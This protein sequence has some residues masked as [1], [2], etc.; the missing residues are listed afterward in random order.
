ML[1]QKSKVLMK[2]RSRFI[3]AIACLL[4]ISCI[5]LVANAQQT[6]KERAQQILD[7]TGVKGGLIIHVGCRDAALTAGLHAND[8]YLVQGLDTNPVYVETARAYIRSQGLYGPVTADR[9][10][11]DSLPYID[12]LVNLVVVD[13]PISVTTDEVMRVLAPNGVAYIKDGRSWTMTVKPRPAGLDEWTHYLYDPSN[14]AVSQDSVIAPLGRFQWLGSPKWARHH[15]RMASVTTYIAAGGRVFY[16][17]D[18]GS[19]ASVQLPSRWALFARD[20]FNGTILWKRPIASWVTQMWPFKSG[21]ALPPRRLVAVGDRVYVTL[22]LDGTALSQLDAA[23]GEIIQTYPD[24]EMTEEVIASEGVL[25]LSVKDAPPTTTWNE[26]RPIHR[27]IG[28]AK[29]RVADEYP[30]DEAS[31]RIMAI[32]AQTGTVLWQK[33]YPAAP[34]TLAVAG[35]RVYFHDGNRIICLNRQNGNQLWA[36]TAIPRWMAMPPKFGPTLVVHDDVVLFEGGDSAKALTALSASTGRVLWTSNHPAT[37]HNCPYDL[38]VAGGLAWVGAI[39]GGSHSGIFT[40]WDPKTGTV[41]SEFPP[42]VETHWFHHRCYRA[43]ATDKYLLTSR[44]GIE[45]VDHQAQQWTIHHWVRGGCLYGILPANGLI[46]TPPHDCACYFES[47]NFGFCALAPVHSDPQYPH[48]TP[49]ADRLEQGPAYPAPAAGAG[50]AEAAAD[51]DWPTYRCDPNRSGH[52]QSV[53]PADLKLSWQTQLQGRLTSPVVANGR[54]YVASVDLHTVY[55]LNEDDGQVL[56]SYMAGGRVDSPPSVYKGGVIFGCADGYVYCLRASDGALI[57]RFQ[58]APENLRMTSFEQVESVWPVPGSVLVLNDTIYC[59]AGRSMFLDG[60]LRLL[61]LDPATGHKLDEV[62]LD[63]RD[64]DTGENLQV[65]IK[66]LNMPVA[67]PDILSSDGEYIYMHSQRFD[68]QGNREE[69]P[70]YSGD[71]NEQGS[72]QYGV[73]M[74]LFSPTGFLDDTY[75][76]RTYWVWGRKWASGAG[77][78]H[79]AGAYAPAGRIMAIG[80]TR[81]YGYGRQPQYFKWT[82]PLEYQLFCAEK[83]PQSKSIEYHWTDNSVPLLVRAMVLADKTLFIAGPPD[84][85]DE[86]VAFDYWANPDIDSNIPAKL[87]EQDAALGGQRGG[88]LWAVSASDGNRVGQYNLESPP[89]WDGMAVANGRLYLSLQNGKVQRLVGT[90]YPPVIDAGQD[91]SIYPMAT[92]VLD[93]TV[94]DDGLPRTDPCDPYSAPIGVTTNWSKLDGPGEVAFGDPCAVD[95]TASFSQWGEYTLRLTAFD[96]SAS[97]YDDINISVLRPGDLDRDKDVD[98]FDLVRFVTQWRSGGCDVLNDWCSGADQTANGSVNFGD[99]SIMA[100]NWLLGVHPAVPTNLVAEPGDSRISLDWDDNTEADLAG[101][102]VYRS[103]SHGSDYTKVNQSLLTNSQYADTSVSNCITFYYVVTAEDAFGYGSDYSDEV[104]AS[105]GIQPVMKLI[106]GIGV[107][108]SGADVSRWQDQANNNHA[109][110]DT[111][112][113][114]P[115]LIGSAI[116]GKPAIAF[117]GAGEHLDVADSKD[118]NTGGPYSGKTLVVVFKTGSN[119]TSRQVIWEQG[120]GTRGLNIY[121]DSGKLYI[122]GWNLDETQALWGP[123]GLN[124]PVSANTTYVAT[125][126][127]NSGAGTFEGFVNG[128]RIGNIRGIGQLYNHSDDCAF[129]HKE[130]GTKFHDGT[131]S[132]TG[133]FVG[134]IAEFYLYNAV[135][136]SSDRQTLENALMSRYVDTPGNSD[137]VEDVMED[138]EA[139]DF[140]KFPWEDSGDASW[141]I[142][143]VEKN[144][145]NYS[146][147]A[148]SI[149]D[150]QSTTLQVRLDCVSGNITFYRK[151]S[152]ELRC[153][154]LK[155]NIDGVRKGSW[156]GKE[157]WTEV[158]FPVT[159]GT[160]IFEW[161]YSKDSSISDGDDTV[162]VDDIVF[163]IE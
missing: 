150:D 40:G 87:N 46:Y 31:R 79:R 13:Q 43:K 60:G 88:L 41:M 119:I 118:I 21:P 154:Y 163:P 100:A 35:N 116:N 147:Q 47:K 11:G 54:V 27:G 139:N 5:I 151:V 110:Q 89:V 3:T 92:A 65:H 30:W 145:G 66:R 143:S 58:A 80:D 120:G 108:T 103:V 113:E 160:R 102:N 63:D 132:G 1:E 99:Y 86:E 84:V 52:T 82:T 155:F 158:S 37:G 159:A 20:A 28:N 9:L 111:P 161:S 76:H 32:Q 7:A 71:H 17:M 127:V 94:T 104:S 126:V 135:L 123:T 51:E 29:S 112:E 107:A 59:V 25:F 98:V 61:Q 62:V 4:A 133:N 6:P 138:F 152:S 77:G 75:M 93:A 153:D 56:W 91:Q 39:A 142:S 83:Y 130:G 122:N 38:L 90:N 95:T 33:Q 128:T 70:P 137:S 50:L 8:S 34:L 109:K 22:G 81:V 85:V 49:D 141:A 125:L 140:S 15:D 117:N 16:I 36:S 69:I 115:E 156:S 53:V 144:S 157:D 2:K 14:N 19:R 134:R 68:L 12:N 57:W 114:R 96:S 101:Y 64:P 162:W 148:G 55:A 74:H 67:L 10:L 73:G 97:Y 146:A 18:Q 45:F 121:L 78:Y 129:G 72:Q 44:T 136:S 124:S 26:Y 24:T 42:D 149:D 23:T 131:N 105:P 106:A 48:T